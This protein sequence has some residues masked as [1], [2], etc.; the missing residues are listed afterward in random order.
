MA[1]GGFGTG[2]ASGTGPSTQYRS[3]PYRGY[4]ELVQWFEEFTDAMGLPLDIWYQRFIKPASRAN[5]LDPTYTPTDVA[6]A[7]LATATAAPTAASSKD[8]MLDVLAYIALGQYPLDTNLSIA[9]KQALTAVGWT[10]LKRKGTRLQI[11]NLA[12]KMADGVAVGWTVPPF[13]FSV[14]LPDGEPSPGYG[15]WVQPA[16]ANAETSRPWL[17]PAIRN[18]LSYGMF[19]DWSN[20]GVGYSQFRANYSSA[21]ETVFAS[22]AR[23]DVLTHEHFDT[24]AAGTPTGWTKTGLATLTQSTSDTSINWEFTGSAAVLDL[25]AQPSGQ[26]V[27][28]S[29]TAANINNQFTHKLQL[30][31][32]YTNTQLVSVLTIQVTD[33]NSDG[34]TY[35]WNPTAATWST[36]AYTIAVP[37]STARGR[38]A[39][40][41]IPQSASSTS[42]TAGTS[43]IAAKV[44]A[45]SDGTASTQTTFTLYRVGLYEKFNLAIEQAAL[46][47]RSAWFP[48]IDSPGW[49]TA[50]RAAVTGTI[51]EP[52][53]ATR[54]SYKVLPA[55]TQATFP[56][57]PALS[58]RGFRATTAWTNLI[59]GSNDFGSDWTLISCTKSANT[60]ISPIV[61]ETV[62]T[63]PT[64]TANAGSPDIQQGFAITPTNKSYVGGI[65]VKKLSSDSN[66]TDVKVQLGATTIQSQTFTVTQAQG[67]TLLPFQFN[68]GGAEVN[69]MN[70]ALKWG[71]ASSNGQIAVADA[72]LYDVTGKTG[73]LYP[74]IIRSGVGA[75]GVLTKTACQAVSSSQ[76]VNVLHPLT[77][78]ALAS[79]T[80]GSL[81]LNVV[82]TFS[83][84]S[85]P[86]GQ[87]VF[88]LAQGAARNRVVLRVNSGALEL[89]R[90]DDSGNAWTASITLSESANPTAGAM[91]WLRDQAV[92][93]HA[94]WDENSTLLT[95]GAGT[96]IGTKPG[97]WAPLDTSVASL[98]VGVDF[99]NAANNF[100][101]F[102]DNV[103]PVQLGAPVA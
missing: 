29:Q 34:N 58:G 51:I 28:L 15:S 93:I 90:W 61:G 76:G 54:T 41:I 17:L 5:L 96:A 101:G 13:N 64:L 62:A 69:L 7:N 27:A 91:T 46:G 50:S 71:A 36:T 18:T 84:S 2:G 12:S 9:Q 42:S 40:D 49:T 47:E 33:A 30:D 55:S 39:C 75:T 56:Y 23:I 16:A 81:S 87:V 78:R 102:I 79:V 38:Y 66:Y 73:V 99:T 85:Q 59:K 97:S 48:L 24:W 21:G 74:P 6:D 1:V 3:L 67:W 19:P 8:T 32:K 89:K 20:L 86:T 103:A 4:R 60:V 22:G 14:I 11:L 26:F 44:F 82:P 70:F 72:Y 68:F 57:H 77:L 63:A 98:T 53:N 92:S 10:A 95:A 100:D 94:I 88:D 25:T 65:W 45:T 52:A 43:S 83:A 35:Y 31:Y 80:R 37:P